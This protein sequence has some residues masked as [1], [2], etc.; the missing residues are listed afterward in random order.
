M[1][2]VVVVEEVEEVVVVVEVRMALRGRVRRGSQ[3]RRA[4]R[5]GWMFL[6]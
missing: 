4:W 3:E 1:V 5:V 2:V 6:R